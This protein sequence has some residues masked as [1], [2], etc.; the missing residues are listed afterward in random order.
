MFTA[1]FFAILIVAV[2]AY[3]ESGGASDKQLATRKE[4]DLS[5]QSPQRS[6]T[7]QRYLGNNRGP[8]FSPDRRH[9]WDGEKWIRNDGGFGFGILIGIL[10]CAAIAAILYSLING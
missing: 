6:Y 2:L 8:I 3:L 9:I 1:A 10:I 7:S 4:S 5:Y